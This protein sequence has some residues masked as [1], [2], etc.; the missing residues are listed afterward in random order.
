M[1]IDRK[2]VLDILIELVKSNNEYLDDCETLDHD[3]ALCDCELPNFYGSTVGDTVTAIFVENLEGFIGVVL[4]VVEETMKGD[5]GSD[6]I[7]DARGIPTAGCPNCGEQWLNVP[8]IF[9]DDTY[10]V[11]AWG[12]EGECFSCGTKVTVATP[13]DKEM[14]GEE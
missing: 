7:L 6:R 11:S 12:T 4:D 3:W 2:R 10:E 8:I 5:N 14:E 9:D 13:A 1:A